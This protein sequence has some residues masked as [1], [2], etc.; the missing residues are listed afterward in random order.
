MVHPGQ[1]RFSLT[2][3]QLIFEK[4]R[5]AAALA[6]ISFAV[7]LILVQIGFYS[8]MN[9][10]ATKVLRHLNAQL[11]VIPA[12]FEFFGSNHDFARMR[13]MQVAGIAGVKEVLPLYYS[14]CSFK[15]IDTGYQRWIF[16]IGLEPGRHML[17]LPEVI[18]QENKMTITGD[19]LFDKKS[20]GTYF[21]T[22][23][24]NFNHD[25][26][27]AVTV[28]GRNVTID[29]LFDLGVTFAA[30][31][32]VLMGVQ[33]F[34]ELFPNASPNLVNVGLVRLKKGMDPGIMSRK[35]SRVLDGKDIKVLTRAEFVQHEINYWNNTAAI[36]FLFIV[37][38]IMGF[39][40][41]AV[42][43]YQIL[44][45]NVIN[46]L[47]EFATLKALGYSDR[48][49]FG[50]VLKQSLILSVL[51]FIPGTLLSWVIYHYT[52]AATGYTMNLSLDKAAIA[53]TSTAIMCVLAGLL[54]MRQLKSADPAELFR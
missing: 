10:S 7:L 36:G 3:R 48:F 15:N 19:V 53:F 47:P 6:G 43:V 4:R 32:N 12:G 25:G 5:L 34:F 54:A 20:L 42:I 37:G 41:G 17:T 14:F 40:I 44:Y 22:V 29:G 28:E 52:A 35:I 49:F 11:V 23:V 13:L 39:I 24:D 30:F 50:L 9:N 51:G 27:F 31:G 8:A 26:P 46:H 45:T 33:T 21:G 2:W 38:A 18:A 1:E 16:C